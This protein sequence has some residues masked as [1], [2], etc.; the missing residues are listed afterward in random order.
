MRPL[1]SI[2]LL[3]L[4]VGHS[5]ADT[6]HVPGDAATIQE[7]IDAAAP[8]DT[9]LVASGTYTG[10][11]NRDLDFGGKSVVLMSDAGPEFT[12]I[13]CEASARAFVLHSGEDSTTVVRG[14]TV[15]NGSAEDG[16]GVF[17]EY[18][19][20]SGATFEDCVFTRCSAQDGGAFYSALGAGTR[21][22]NCA[23]L[24][25]TAGGRGGAVHSFDTP[26]RFEGCTFAGNEAAI[27]GAMDI[28]VCWYRTSLTECV[29]E[30]N[31]ATWDGGAAVLTNYISRETQVPPAM[32]ARDRGR[33]SVDIS[34]CEF[35]END[36]GTRGGALTVWGNV[37]EFVDLANC[38]FADN[39]APSGGAIADLGGVWTLS[40]SV[41]S[42]NSAEIGGAIYMNCWGPWHLD[43]CTFVW[44]TAATGAAISWGWSD[45][46]TLERL[47]IAFSSGGP[48]VACQE[49]QPTFRHSLAFGNTAGDSLC[50]S[51]D[52][53]LS[54]DPLFCGALEDDF[55]LCVNSPC[56]PENNA[57][58]E[59]VGALG[60]GCGE[61]Y[62]G[63]QE[64]T[65]GRIKAGFK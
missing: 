48:A 57:W 4:L 59:L 14:F 33:W 41:F 58:G 55:T 12:T 38:L 11:L 28:G 9:V 6:V 43:G 26:L 61:C 24:G 18:S 45:S 15:A 46:R 42:R 27:G 23:F 21:F 3:L 10:A 20:S 36:A 1:L 7:G 51:L 30:S 22:R 44:N 64:R 17:A 52:G 31:S 13:D 53:M 60:E 63:I 65:W 35:L 16:G 34:S 50:G 54:D 37:G 25:N 29:F 49:G 32:D 40:G 2:G 56:L 47:I 5:V 62:S 39:T 19:S 8:G